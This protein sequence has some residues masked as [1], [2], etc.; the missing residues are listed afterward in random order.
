MATA[1]PPNRSRNLAESHQK[2]RH[3][4]EKLRGYIRSYVTLE[5]A[6]V[7]L[8]FLAL[9][10]WIG[11]V[12]D[13]GFFKSFGI[14]WVQKLPWGFRAFLLGVLTSGALA[15]V[16]LQVLT[17]LFREFRDAA[18]AL[19]LERKFPKELGDRLI[20][21]VELADTR[22]AGEVGYSVPMI[23]ETIHEA[24][25]RVEKLPVQQVFDWKRLYRQGVRVA[26][27]TL[28]AYLLACG[29]FVGI[30]KATADSR[31][32]TALGGF[33]GFNETAG[34]WFE[35]NILLR[36]VIWP[37]RSHL[38]LVGFPAGGELRIGRDDPPPTVRVRALKYV[39]S[40]AP[41]R[42]A[43]EAYRAWLDARHVDAAAANE[44]AEAFSHKPPE[45]WRPLT[46]FDLTPELLGEEVPHLELPADWKPRDE[47]HGLTLD[48]IELLLDKSDASQQ[49]DDETRD[50]LRGLFEQLDRRAAL[51]E[52]RRT[53]RKL[54]VPDEV[55][56]GYRGL[57]SSGQQPLQK[58]ADNEYSGQLSSLKE[59]GELPWTFTFTV[60]GEDY[61]TRDLKI[62]IL[63]PPAITKLLSQESRPA[64]LYYR[65]A[66]GTDPGVLSGKKQLFN[67]V[68][69][70]QSTS[71]S[72]TSKIEV[73]AGTDVVLTGV[74]NKE[75]SS[76][77]LQPRKAG[78]VVKAKLEMLDKP[79]TA[80]LKDLKEFKDRVFRVEFPNVREEVQFLFEMRDRDNVVGYRAVVIK[81][82]DDFAP[83]VDLAVG[84]VIRKTKEGYMVTPSARVPFKGLVRDDN[85]LAD[86][87]YAY[88]VARLE[89][90]SAVNVNALLSL[91][92]LPMAAPGAGN[93]L[94]AA[95]YLQVVSRSAAPPK[96]DEAA[97]DV[98][99]VPLPR[100]VQSLKDHAAGNVKELGR[101][102][103]AE[104][105]PMP[106]VRELL[107]T[108]RSLP[109]RT[110]FKDFAIEPDLW[111]KAEIDALGNDFPMWKAG[112][113]ATGDRSVQL[114]YKMQL[115]L[116][117]TDGDVD[118]E[119][120]RDGSPKP[121]LSKSKEVFTFIIVSET[122]L[123]TEIAKDE[124]KQH[125][126][127]DKIMFDL[128]ATEAKL[129]QANLDLAGKPKAD[130]LTALSARTDEADQVLDKSQV[131]VKEVLSDYQRILQELKVNQV[132]E[133]MIERVEKEIVRPL[134]EIDAV[135][136]P[137]TR[138]KV[139]AF[140]KDL[141]NS[142][143]GLDERV[144]AAKTSGAAAKEQIKELIGK[145]NAVLQKMQGLTDLNKLVKILRDIEEQEQAQW[146]LME[147]IRKKLEDTIF[148]NL[149]EP[150]KKPEEKKKP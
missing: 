3:P 10:F 13:Y 148:N 142:G 40:G 15:L 1:T 19:V 64:Y 36:D 96:P 145:L 136:F 27:L 70:F 33:S 6:A 83:D 44:S 131:V 88:T 2:V 120:E 127:L 58:S 63:P 112:L 35:R 135:E 80:E 123:L 53:F 122:E 41:R 87:R 50:A 57:T 81:P 20:T 138:D 140:R 124:E 24:G 134:E 26:L 28:G 42:H 128:L 55:V 102:F 52:M 118:S 65:P 90:V 56:L 141:D 32:A 77:R 114:R 129:V 117:A 115:W 66:E 93:P 47:E 121:H 97:K 62:T 103:V 149:L 86:V 82:K 100:F 16:A 22:K 119:K 61:Y 67:P 110:L 38:V 4:L 71:G 147:M 143:A 78:G 113:K 144:A 146:D 107:G 75:L 54:K 76:V 23:E 116:E 104:F 25:E 84:D 60:R 46:W 126:K 108:P 139:G 98:K 51:P 68:D 17:R 94:A 29:L 18:L 130:E 85:G 31:F 92:A 30:D 101:G 59:N 14:D 12:L 150:G 109:Y 105:L 37:R 69:I 9:W 133:K 45:G 132:D 99:R 72:D 49:L 39:V 125:E 43:V 5:G 74:A 91:G 73:P 137:A 95:V 79:D 34:I 21:A 106:T 7:F 89:A 11:L 8:L 48:Q 111:E